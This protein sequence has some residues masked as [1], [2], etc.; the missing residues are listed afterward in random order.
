VGETEFAKEL[1]QHFGEDR[2]YHC[3]LRVDKTEGVA[4]AVHLRSM[5]G[6]LEDEPAQCVKF[7]SSIGI[8]VDRTLV[9]KIFRH[10]AEIKWEDMCMIA[11]GFCK[12][13]K[14]FGRKTHKLPAH[15]H[16][17]M[18]LGAKNEWVE[19]YVELLEDLNEQTDV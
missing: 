9:S 2:F 8:N 7:F 4:L 12:F 16:A 15:L 10:P 5:L 1:M 14:E 18:I 13:W 11:F 6:P 3:C 19:K 17:R